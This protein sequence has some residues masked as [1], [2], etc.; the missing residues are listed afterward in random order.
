[1]RDLSRNLSWEIFSMF[2]GFLSTGMLIKKIKQ[3]FN[4]MRF[5]ILVSGNKAQ[6]AKLSPHAQVLLAFG[7]LK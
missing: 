1:M 2:P 5:L 6:T 3:H 4:F 7:L